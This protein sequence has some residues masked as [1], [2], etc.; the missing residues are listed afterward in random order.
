LGLP[1]GLGGDEKEPYKGNLARSLLPFGFERGIR[2]K[3]GY[4]LSFSLLQAKSA[5]FSPGLSTWTLPDPYSCPLQSHREAQI[6]EIS[7]QGR[8]KIAP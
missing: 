4:T 2:K 6:Q 1:G 3:S 8:G 5:Q 7:P